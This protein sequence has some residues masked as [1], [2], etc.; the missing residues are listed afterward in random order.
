M[1]LPLPFDF[2]VR[3]RATCSLDA[4]GPRDRTSGKYLTAIN[5]TASL[6]LYKFYSTFSPS[7][8]KYIAASLLLR[9]L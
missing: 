2:G 7:I 5:I 6:A 4:D 3:A 9:V 8:I 1:L